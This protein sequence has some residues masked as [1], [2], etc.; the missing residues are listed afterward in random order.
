VLALALALDRPQLNQNLTTKNP[1]VALT[2]TSPP[3]HQARKLMKIAI[4]KEM[5]WTTQTIYFLINISPTTTAVNK[6][7]S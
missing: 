2:A 6:K 5:T 7:T 4:N 1:L 3:S